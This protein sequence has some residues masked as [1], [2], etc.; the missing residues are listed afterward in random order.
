MSE[1]SE[2]DVSRRRLL[3]VGGSV[4]V[5]A[6][7]AGCTGGTDGTDSTAATSGTETT[8]TETTRSTP[9][10]DGSYSVTME[11]MGEVAFESVPES[12]MAYFSTYGDMGVALGQLDGL[13]G[14]IFTDNW[15]LQF[16]DYLPG[17]EVSFDDVT[18]LFGEGSLDKEAFYA[19]DSDVH[20]MDPNFIQRLDDN[21][22]D[23]DFEEIATNVGPIIGNSIRR[24]GEEWHDYRYYSL[25]DAFEKIAQVFQE[26][27]RYRALKRV[28]DSFI[29]DVQ[30][31]LPAEADRPKVGLLSVNSDFEEGSFYAYP[32]V[33]GGNGKKQYQDLGIGDAFGEHIDGGYAKWDYEQLLEADPDALVFS[34]GFSHATAEQFE[35]RMQAMREDPVGRQLSAVQNDRLYR[36]GTSYQG[37]IVN[38]FQTEIAAKQFYPEVFGAWNGLDTL[39]DESQRLFDHQQVADVIT[40]DF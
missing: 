32:T 11:P 6:G 5:T 9:T 28:H 40:G 7:L 35:S 23:E 12:W 20:L 24:R 8:P 27:E 30:S 4:A 10:D 2:T 33:D 26:R 34:Y 36:G 37:P 39:A 15:P 14:L 1:Q 18:Q 29:A 3:T 16:Y 25:Y 13:Q 22:A 19:M 38:L 31:R 17:V 21:W